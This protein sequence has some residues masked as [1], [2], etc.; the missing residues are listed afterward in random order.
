MKRNWM[1]TVWLLL[2]FFLLIYGNPTMFLSQAGPIIVPHYPPSSFLF[3]IFSIFKGIFLSAILA[4]YLANRKIQR[5]ISL[6]SLFL[7]LL[8][9][10]AVIRNIQTLH[11]M[12]DISRYSGFSPHGF[13]WFN[14]VILWLVVLLGIL[15]GGYLSYKFEN[16]FLGNSLFAFTIVLLLFKSVRFLSTALFSLFKA[17]SPQEIFLVTSLTNLLDK[18]LIYIEYIIIGVVAIFIPPG[19]VSMVFLASLAYSLGFFGFPS[20]FTSNISLNALHCLEVCLGTTIPTLLTL[21]VKSYLERKGKS[22]RTL[23]F[24]LIP[25]LLIAFILSHILLAI[26]SHPARSRV[27]KFPLSNYDPLSQAQLHWGAIFLDGKGLAIA[28]SQRDFIEAT[29]VPQ[30]E[31]IKDHIRIFARVG[32]TGDLPLEG[33][34]IS[35]QSSF[36]SPDGR[37]LLL[38]GIPLAK[39][40][41]VK[42]PRNLYLMDLENGTIRLIDNNPCQDIYIYSPWNSESSQFLYAGYSKETGH[43][44]L[45][46]CDLKG[47]KKKL[48]E[49]SPI[50]RDYFFETSSAGGMWDEKGRDIYIWE[51]GKGVFRARCHELRIEKL[52]DSPHIKEKRNFSV[53]L[54]PSA[55]IL[56]FGKGDESPNVPR[57]DYLALFDLTK[58]KFLYKKRFIHPPVVI[59]PQNVKV[60]PS[61]KGAILLPETTLPELNVLYRGS[62]GKVMSFSLKTLATLIDAIWGKDDAIYIAVLSWQ[63]TLTPKDIIEIY[64]VRIVH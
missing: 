52:Y 26:T 60:A 40:T 39:K 11:I 2:G 7:F 28:Y 33:I 62:N 44:A 63:S 5:R 51:E 22:E 18:L 12:R 20:F 9:I 8:L 47:E 49:Y 55:G 32:E 4:G 50:E 31:R 45:F 10:Y 21:W 41:A 23:Q 43:P 17:S 34:D 19:Y 38:Y 36:S 15:L 3:S 37:W 1:A 54:N 6:N 16:T 30:A 24:T 27:A 13:T 48:F 59:L 56:L 35:E 14:Q 61:G 58:G 42:S 64:R 46:L 53:L 29:D 57:S 25:F